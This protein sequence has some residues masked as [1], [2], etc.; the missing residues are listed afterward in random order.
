VPSFHFEQ[1]KTL[2]FRG[3]RRLVRDPG[4]GFAALPFNFQGATGVLTIR[5]GRRQ[6]NKG[7]WFPEAEARKLA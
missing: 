2:H 7:R 1:G 3:L 5:G 4:P 6:R